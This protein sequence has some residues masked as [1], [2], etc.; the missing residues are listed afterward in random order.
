MKLGLG[1]IKE[2]DGALHISTRGR[3]LHMGIGMILGAV[4][5]AVVAV[6]DGEDPLFMVFLVFATLGLLAVIDQLVWA[7]LPRIIIDPRTRCVVIGK[8]QYPW[9]DYTGVVR[10]HEPPGR[11]QRTEPYAVYLVTRDG[12][13]TR[14]ARTNAEEAQL[15]Q[16]RVAHMLEVPT[17]PD[18][19]GQAL[20]DEWGQ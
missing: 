10:I 19:L 3:R 6:V 17:L 15:L 12:A 7:F 8:T 18:L 13:R 2:V 1:L 14:L 11:N 4:M 16:H 9:S 5:A 20:P